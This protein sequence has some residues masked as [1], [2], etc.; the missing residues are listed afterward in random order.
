METSLHRQLKLHYAGDAEQT[1]VMVDGFRIDAIAGCGELIEI[2]HASLGAL[3]EKTKRLLANPENRLRVVKPIL[4]RKRL[5]TLTRRHGSVKRTRMSPKRGELLD[6]FEDFVHFAS[7]FPR[8]RLTLELLLIESEEHRLDR[9]RPSR[10][11]LR[12]RVLD[13]RLATVGGS[14]PLRSNEDLLHL[15]PLNVLPCPFDTAELANCLGRPRWLA[16]KIAYC[17]RTTGAVR[18]DGKRGNAQLYRLNNTGR[19]RR[20][21]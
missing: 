11:G 16:Q 8:E 7:V 17:L 4:S 1:E 20:S 19:R 9:Q 13:Q 12:Y 10:R 5:V 14:Y 3:R 2:Q 6:V 15:L 21:A 18:I